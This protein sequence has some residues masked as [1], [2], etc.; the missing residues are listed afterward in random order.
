MNKKNLLIGVL[1]AAF[2][3]TSA[4]AIAACDNGNGSGQEQEPTR[5]EKVYAQYVVYAQAEDLE[6]LSYEAWLLSIKGEKGDQGEQGI[7]GEKGDKEDQGEQSIQGEKGET[8]VGIEK[9]EYDKNGDLKITFTDGSTQTVVM[10]DKHVHSFGDWTAFTAEDVP[11]ESRLFFRT[12]ATCNTIEW[13]QGNYEDHDWETVTTEPT[14]QAQGYDT[15][16]CTIC[17]KVEVEN[18]TEIV[19]HP[20]NEEYSYDNSFHWIDCDTCD[21]VK[22]KEE[23]SITDSGECSVCG[24]LVGATEGVIYD[25]STDGTYAEVIGYEGT[26]TKIRFAE[27]YQ[28]LPVKTIYEKAFYENYSITDVIIPDSVTTIGYRAFANCESLTSVVIGDSVTTIGESAFR[29]CTRLTSVTFKNTEGWWYSSSMTATSGTS[30]SS[31]DLADSATAAEYLK[32]TYC[33]Y[34]WKRS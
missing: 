10:T 21:E 5:M 14:C 9:V 2:M 15:K 23:H 1:S 6:P 28:G 4:F 12:C 7:Q 33:N 8:G 17:G 31:T 18:Y 11:C 16:T 25:I 22:E 27:T 26:A 32:S 29:Y 30:I 24:G 34:Y 20:W 13:K 19:D 3:A